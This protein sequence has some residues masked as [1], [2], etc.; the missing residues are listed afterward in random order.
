MASGISQG[1]KGTRP[2]PLILE[3][4]IARFRTKKKNYRGHPIQ[5]VMVMNNVFRISAL[6]ANISIV[7]LK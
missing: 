1:S 5:F 7:Y 4:R 2:I 6:Y 3:T